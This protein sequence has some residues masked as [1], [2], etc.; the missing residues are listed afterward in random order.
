MRVLA[1]VCLA[2]LGGCNDPVRVVAFN[3]L[4]HWSADVSSDVALEI[5]TRCDLQGERVPDH[6]LDFVRS[7]SEPNCQLSLRLA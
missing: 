6:L 7:Y 4:E 2:L 5:E 1:L 3:T